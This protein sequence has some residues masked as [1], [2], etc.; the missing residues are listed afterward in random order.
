VALAAGHPSDANVPVVALRP[1]TGRTELMDAYTFACWNALVVA[2]VL[3]AQRRLVFSWSAIGVFL[4]ANLV[5]L[6]VGVLGVPLFREYAELTFAT[7]NLGMVTE[8]DYKLAIV[9]TV[10]GAG[11]VLASYQLTHVALNG[12]RPMRTGPNLLA[13]ARGNDRLGMSAVR[14]VV[15]SG[16]IL[17]TAFGYAA[18]SASRILAGVQGALAGSEAS[19][20]GARYD[21]GADYWFILT[22]LDVLPFLGVAVRLLQRLRGGPGLRLFAA[23]FNTGT[24]ALLLLTF[25]KRPLLL[26]LSCLLLT[27]LV[28]DA[29]H[30]SRSAQPPSQPTVRSQGRRRR[31]LRLAVYGLMIFAVLLGLYQLQTQ[32]ISGAEGAGDVVRGI[33]TLSGMALATILGGQ[34]VPAI[35]FAHYYPAIEPHY[36]VSNL[37]LFAR[38]FG[39]DLYRPTYEVYDYFVGFDSF[40]PFVDRTEGSVASAALVD[41]YGAFGLVGWFF[42]ALGLGIV[43]NLID[44]AMIRLR[45]D[46][47]RSLLAIF[48]FVSVYYLS[49][50]S[51]AN[52]LAGYGG[53]I[54]LALWWLLRTPFRSAGVTPLHAARRVATMS[55][56]A[57]AYLASAATVQAQGVPP[58]AHDVRSS[59]AR[60]DGVNDDTAAIR[61]ALQG[62][63]A[64]AYG[65]VLFPPGAGCRVT[66]T[67]VM[68]RAIT[69]ECPA[70]PS[71]NNNAKT[72]CVIEHDFVGTL[73]ELNGADAGNPGSGY[74]IRNLVLRQKRGNG[75]AT[76]GAG[77][78][79]RIVGTSPNTRATWVH[80]D[81]IQIEDGAGADPWT[82]GIDIDGS[83]MAGGDSVRDVWITS[84][85]ILNSATAGTPGAVRILSAQN[86]F[87]TNLFLNGTGGHLM[88]S[89]SPGK[90][91]NTVSLTQVHG[92][93]LAMD[94]CENL[95]LVGGR[96]REITNTAHTSGTNLLIPTT[97]TM[98]FR[99]NAGAAM[100]V[101][102]ADPKSGNFALLANGVQV[103]NDRGLQGLRAGGAP[104]DAIRVTPGDRVAVDGSGL[105]IVAGNG[106]VPLTE[107][108]GHLRAGAGLSFATLPA[109][110]N[111]TLIYCADCA[112]TNPCA[113]GGTGAIA[114][115]LNGRWVCN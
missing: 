1:G 59:G 14:L 102:V 4:V 41:F 88:C 85:R 37:G 57:V 94:Y 98:P 50:A 91:T 108:T 65:V 103:P 28:A 66:S 96:W 70:V 45:P 64:A 2:V 34:A 69:L 13:L 48:V 8:S 51:V 67:I 52:T 43:L 76:A 84:G 35:L 81:N 114:K 47:A 87:L 82:L 107:P 104:A 20:L 60:C 9:L 109:A 17:L 55:A 112:T 80:I 74:G 31:P 11:V 10:W 99:N 5:I 30:A 16:T 113:G 83:Q 58:G 19:I 33:A 78:A 56:V 97:L 12:G 93:V 18:V 15:L 68:P 24:G 40:V 90:T 36:G 111:G 38:L 44:A 95:S 54:F 61:T 62:A 25:Q 110:S 92:Q 106:A 72:A 6:Q 22:V 32:V 77:T 29:S 75:T 42:G 86:V 7:F 39:W 71:Q 79:I 63:G 115:R 46:A 23:I 49:N 105:G 100:T 53:L 89:G 26:F 21:I 73:F 27:N 3:T 101:A